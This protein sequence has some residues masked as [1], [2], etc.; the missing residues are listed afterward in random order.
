MDKPFFNG[1]FIHSQTK[2]KLQYY[3]NNQYHTK[4]TISLLVAELEDREYKILDE[5]NN[6][7]V[8][9]SSAWRLRW[10]FQRNIALNGGN[11]DV[12]ISQDGNAIIF[13]YYV[14]F[15]PLSLL[16]TFAVILS[17]TNRDYYAALLAVCICILNGVIL[18]VRAKWAA[19]RILK[20]I[21]FRPRRVS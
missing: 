8:F 6:S 17:I 18:I 16:A 1:P 14:D 4:T 7:L 21:L 9:Y 2:V 20:K 5:T 10:N 11:A 19:K 13:N 15:F 12:G 3:P